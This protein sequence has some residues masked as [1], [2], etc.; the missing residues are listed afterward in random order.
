MK[1]IY[2]TEL[3]Q[4]LNTQYPIYIDTETF[5]MTPLKHENIRLLQ[6]Y[7]PNTEDTVYVVDVMLYPKEMLREY[8]SKFENIFGYNLLYDWSVMGFTFQT[9]PKYNDLYLASKIAFYERFLNPI[10]KWDLYS[11]LDYIGIKIDLDKKSMQTSNFAIQ[12]LT[13]M[14]IKYSA[15]DVYYLPKLKES[16]EKLEPLIWTHNRVYRLDLFVSKSLLDIHKV[17]L[18]VNEELRQKELN[19]VILELD[20]ILQELS[21]N[22]LS[23]KQVS[24]FFKTHNADEK[25]LTLLASQGSEVAKKVLYARQLSKIKSFLEKY[26]GRVFGSFNVVGAKSGRM[27]S[28]NENLQQIPRQL[29]KVFGF[30]EISNKTYVIADFPQI[31]LRLAGIIWNETEMIRAFKEGIDLHKYTASV[32]YKKDMNEITKQERQIAKSA[33]FG[34]LYGMGSDRFKDY[35][36]INTGISLNNEE[37]DLIK[38]N[39]FNLFKAIKMKHKEIG[40]YLKAYS[41]YSNI[42]WLGRKYCTTSYTEALNLQIQGSGADLLK[43]TIKNILLKNYDV[44]YRIANI[45]HDEIIIETTKDIAKDVALMLKKEMENAWEEC[46]NYSKLKLENKFKLVCDM[47]DITNTLEK[48]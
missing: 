6:I 20:N 37:T 17:G 48:S 42:T 32:I 34:L 24:N 1:Y 8:L 19:R 46:I 26:S 23:P 38:Y 31:E 47:P 22:P 21:F 27:T 15:Y 45:I 5:G 39:W 14:Q 7:Q 30:N 3:P 33:N 12:C 25:T 43:T 28:S 2:T 44:N 41:Q 16:I 40:A 13:D 10:T 9:V 29:R 4:H 11:V 35:I 36:F 18:Q